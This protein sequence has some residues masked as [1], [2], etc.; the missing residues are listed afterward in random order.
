MVGDLDGQVPVPL[1]SGTG[2]AGLAQLW[3]H[4]KFGGAI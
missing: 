4:K 2:L 3:S 1:R